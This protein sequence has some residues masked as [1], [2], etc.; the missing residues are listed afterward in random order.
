M[1][2][3][4]RKKQ[5]KKSED[6]SVDADLYQF[7]E[8]RR[9]DTP[10][11]VEIV[12]LFDEDDA[13]DLHSHLNQNGLTGFYVAVVDG[14][15]AGVIGAS[16]ASDSSTTAWLD[17]LYVHP[18][19]QRKG[20]ASFLY[21]GINDSMQESPLKRLFVPVSDFKEDGEDVYAPAR[22]FFE[23]IGGAH[24]AYL[25]NFY[26]KGEGKHIYRLDLKEDND[27]TKRLEA[28]GAEI[29]SVEEIDESDGAFV[30]A[31]NETDDV[32]AL[33]SLKI[34]EL[35]QDARNDGAHTVFCALPVTI[36]DA[37]AGD[38]IDSGFTKL[39]ALKNYYG[40]SMD[41]VY[42]SKSL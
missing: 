31:W 11:I 27:P 14:R 19:I 1:G 41:E 25:P 16:V 36:S 29:I 24:E 13:D 2:L 21:S 39:G 9:G 33:D 37:V 7:R 38:L 22:A 20:V 17:W 28:T 10:E 3:F 18:Q 6:Q 32:K 4:G 40:T 35:L 30:L 12:T 23:K 34:R 26:D 42:W 15:L 8:M 5:E